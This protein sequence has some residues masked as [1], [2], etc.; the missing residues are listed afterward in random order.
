MAE[1]LPAQEDLC[2]NLRLL[3]EHRLEEGRITGKHANDNAIADMWPYDP[4]FPNEQRALYQTI[5]RA[6]EALSVVLRVLALAVVP[7]SRVVNM[8]NGH[9]E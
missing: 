8:V 5:C 1:E 3:N 7:P 2:C 6:C 9:E 4:A